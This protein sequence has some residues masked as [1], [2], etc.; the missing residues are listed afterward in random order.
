[1]W[2]WNDLN[3]SPIPLGIWTLALNENAEGKRSAEIKS[4]VVF[5]ESV[6]KKASS[7]TASQSLISHG[8]QAGFF[9]SQLSCAP[10]KPLPPGPL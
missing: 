3:S 1:M 5:K 6:E 10:R 8:H 9:P 7:L 2:A 4:G